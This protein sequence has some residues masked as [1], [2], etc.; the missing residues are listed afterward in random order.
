MINTMNIKF[1]NIAQLIFHIVNTSHL[2]VFFVLGEHDL[3]GFV[4]LGHHVIPSLASLHSMW[5]EKFYPGDY[6][7]TSR[8]LPSILL[9]HPLTLHQQSS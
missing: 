5:K 9:S 3:V 8:A 1:K 7:I 2:V 6:Y 4:E